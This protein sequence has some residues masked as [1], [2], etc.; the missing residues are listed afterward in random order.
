VF[1]LGWFAR[2][3]GVCRPI[4]R[5]RGVCS[6]WFISNERDP[7][8]MSKIIHFLG[9]NVHKDSITVR[10]EAR[11]APRGV[12]GMPLSE[13][14][15]SHVFELLKIPIKRRYRHL[16]VDGMGSQESIDQMNPGLLT[17]MEGI[18]SSLLVESFDTT[19]LEK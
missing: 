19:A 18:E 12:A 1:D 6:A 10:K 7:T 9:L 4:R 14:M 5:M 3:A 8:P 2:V 11:D 17:A 13:C 16:T 15:A